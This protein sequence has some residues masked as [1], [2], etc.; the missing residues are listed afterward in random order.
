MIIQ[1]N[2]G[3]LPYPD[4][5]PD[6]VEIYDW[7][8]CTFPFKST[9]LAKGFRYFHSKCITLR[10]KVHSYMM[11]GSANASIAAMGGENKNS[12]NHEAIIAIRKRLEELR[13]G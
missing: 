2:F 6:N 7:Q 9:Y 11:V 1:K 10:G 3:A 4:A 5:L 12:L 8:N 13:K